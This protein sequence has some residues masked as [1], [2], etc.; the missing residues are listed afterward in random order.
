MNKLC[1]LLLCLILPAL[2]FA[3]QTL[4]WGIDEELSPIFKIAG[5]LQEAVKRRTEGRVKIIIEKYH[6]DRIENEFHAIKDGKFQIHQMEV[7]E[8]YESHPVL[9][10]WDM[11]FL[12][13]NRKHVESYIES[14]RAEKLLASVEDEYRKHISYSYAGGFLFLF[15]QK[16]LNSIA[17]L[18]GKTCESDG[19]GDQLFQHFFKPRGISRTREGVR[20][21]ECAEILSSDLSFIFSQLEKGHYNHITLSR[22]R[23]LSRI[24]SVSKK[25][26][27]KMQ[28]EDQEVLVEE[29]KRFSRHERSTIY[30]GIEDIKKV[31]DVRGLSYNEWGPETLLREKKEFDELTKRYRSKLKQ[32][33][34]EEINYIEGL[35]QFSESKKL[36]K[37]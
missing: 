3:G 11:P 36:T 31:L 5:D 13:M 20:G 15:T 34:N 4:V 8:F 12:F 22:H 24:L 37:N 32:K 21:E 18:T 17:E 27:S 30:D 26:L 19:G 25:A 23:L 28:P 35:R 1:L 16:K 6:P 10:Y 2:S 33:S 14:P 7:D 29:L 9:K